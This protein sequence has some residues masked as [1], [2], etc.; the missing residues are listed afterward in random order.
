MRKTIL[1]FLAMAFF[2]SMVFAQNAQTITIVNNTG[3][4]GYYLYVSQTA[5]E[6]WGAD[7]LGNATIP[8]GGTFT[9]RLPYPLDVV[10]RYDF[11]LVDT[12]GDS[13]YKWDVQ[14][15]AGSRI[16]FV[17]GELNAR[18]PSG[19]GAL[20]VVSGSGPALTVVNNTGYH[21]YYLYVSA[22]ANDYWGDDWLGSGT[23]PTGYEITINL[24]FPINVVNRYDFRLVDS[25]GDSYTKMNVQVQSNGRVVFVFNDID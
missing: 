24:P 18:N 12:D 21:G 22:T 23:L 4:H 7:R 2:T 11:R 13:Y 19:H 15:Q 20:P 8:N 25:D 3:Y 6:Q 1:I 14:V 17:F 9:M 5:S 10:N 16:I